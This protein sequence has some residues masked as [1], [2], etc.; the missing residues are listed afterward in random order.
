MDLVSATFYTGWAFVL[1]ACVGFFLL[2]RQNKR[3]IRRI[4]ELMIER[5]AAYEAGKA[6][7]DKKEYD[8]AIVDLLGVVS[9]QDYERQNGGLHNKL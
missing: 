1:L 7:R 9:E 5:N 3:L 2:W 8:R 4:E 6:A